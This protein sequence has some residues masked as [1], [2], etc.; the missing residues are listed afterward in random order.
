MGYYINPIAGTKEEWLEQYGQITQE[1]DW[2]PPDGQ[3]LVCLVDNESFTALGIAYDQQEWMTFIAPDATPEEIEAARIKT[4]EVG[5][6]FISLESG[7]QRPRT[8]YLVPR[9]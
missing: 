8:W 1:P 3:V 4:E 2:P 9:D 6:A 5:M 7:K